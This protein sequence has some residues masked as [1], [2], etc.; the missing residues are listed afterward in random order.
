MLEVGELL[1]HFKA[2]TFSLQPTSFND[3][4]KLF[5]TLFCLT[6]L[7]GFAQFGVSYHQSNMPFVGFN[8]EI[9]DRFMPELRFGMDTHAHDMS[10]EAV[11]TYQ[12]LDKEEVEVYA[13]LGGRANRHAGLVAPIGIHVFPFPS[14]NFG[15]HIEV[16]PIFTEHDDAIVRG[17][18]GIRY[19]F[20]KR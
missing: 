9:A 17:S 6:T 7:Q 16:A 3:M 18:W 2:H 10:V 14:R 13:G 19:R 12:F 1:S 8:Y 4:K 11:A 5:T 20:K 15:F